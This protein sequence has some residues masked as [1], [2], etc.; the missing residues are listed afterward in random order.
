[1]GNAFAGTQVMSIPRG[2]GPSAGATGL[3]SCT[4][5]VC[6]PE[7]SDHGHSQVF[8]L[9]NALFYSALYPLDQHDAYHRDLK[10]DTTLPIVRQYLSLDVSLSDLY[11][12]WSRTDRNF[13]KQTSHGRYGGIRVLKQ[14]PWE[15]L[16]G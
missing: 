5:T 6:S 14:D 12:E 1:M 16:V 9:A 15:T 8:H 4:R 2:I 13:V 7:W 11:A 10:E 3:Y